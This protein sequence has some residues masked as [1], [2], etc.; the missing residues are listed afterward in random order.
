MTR[1][2]LFRTACVASLLAFA[3][4][5]ALAQEHGPASEG[6]PA[7]EKEVA[8]SVDLAGLVFPVF[9]EKGKLKNYLFVSARLL[10]AP[11]KDTWKYREQAHFIRDAVVRAAHR[12]SFNLK[13]DY[14]KLDEKVAATECLKAANEAVGEK[15]AMIEM[16][17]TQVASQS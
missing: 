3:A 6:Q 16:T 4:P 15:G 8:R 5:Q 17:F 10:V 14:K 7:N 9:D 11:D 2:D 13:G 1:R 12:V